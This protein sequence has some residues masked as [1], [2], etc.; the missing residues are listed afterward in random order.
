MQRKSSRQKLVTNSYPDREWKKAF[1]RKSA[2][3]RDEPY[4]GEERKGDLRGESDGSSP[5]CKRA[6]S[7]IVG[8]RM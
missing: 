3:I 7:M 1:S 6:E 5:W 2:L 8:A 4:S